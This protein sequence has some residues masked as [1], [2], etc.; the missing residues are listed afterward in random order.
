MPVPD[1]QAFVFTENGH[2]GARART[3]KEFI[4]LLATLPAHRLVGYF[5]RH[6]CSHWV[7]E[8][9]RDHRLAA[10]VHKIEI[11]A[12][13]EDTREVADAIEQAIRARYE[14]AVNG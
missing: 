1:V 2:P 12:E 14:T 7:D 6:D 3:L 5:R 11:R 8:V 10:H 13:S 4:G 9:F